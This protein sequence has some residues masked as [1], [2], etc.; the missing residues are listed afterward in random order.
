MSQIVVD[1]S[2]ALSWCFRDE[3]SAY[4]QAVL[5]FLETGDAMVPQLFWIEIANATLVAERRGRIQPDDLTQFTE[6]LSQLQIETDAGSEMR[7]LSEVRPLAQK[8]SLTVYDS[9][10][11]DLAMRESLPLATLDDALLRAAKNRGVPVFAS[12]LT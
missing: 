9:I 10:Y 6:L 5:D 11:L 8:E 4:S 12:L 7:V 2:V 1:A 3:A